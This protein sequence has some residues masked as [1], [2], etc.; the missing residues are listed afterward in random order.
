MGLEK[1][2]EKR[3]FTSSPEPKEEKSKARGPLR[4]VIQ[5]HQATRLHYDLRLEMHG[6]LKSW[7]VPKGP[8]LNPKDKRLAVMTEDHPIKYLTFEGVIPKGNYGAGVMH[9]WDTGTYHAID[10]DD[11]KK[12][13]KALISGLEEGD[14]KFILEGNIV[15]GEF[16]LIKA[17]SDEKN[18]LLIKKKDTHA[19]STAFNSE[20]FLPPEIIFHDK[21]KKGEKAAK[22]APATK[23]NQ[24]AAPETEDA[25]LAYSP[26]PHNVKP[27]LAQLANEPF[28]DPEWI[29]ELKWDGYRAIA[30]VE[31]SKVNIYSRNG[32]P[33]N[34][35]FF[36]LVQHLKKLGQ[37][38]VL[39]GEIVVLSDKGHP[40]FQKL[41]NFDEKDSDNLCFYVFDLL[42]LNGYD[43]TQLPL[44]ERKKL[45]REITEGLTN[46]FYS[47]HIKGEGKTFFKEAQKNK[48]EGIIA[49]RANSTY[50]IGARSKL[51]LKIK[52]SMRQE[53]IIAGFTEGKGSRKHF[54]SLLL[55]LYNGQKLVYIGNCGGGFNEE[56]LKEMKNKLTP[57]ITKENPFKKK[58]AAKAPITWVEPRLVCEITFSEW[59]EEGSMRHPIFF[60]LREDKDPTNVVKEVPI[61]EKEPMK[62]EEKETK[63]AKA[64]AA[65]PPKKRAKKDDPGLVTINGHELKLTNLDKIY[66]PEEKYTKGDL[67]SYYRTI[68]SYILPYLADRPES[69]HRHPNGIGKQSFFQKD[70]KDMPPDWIQT[71]EIHSES[72]DKDINYLVCQDEATLVYMNNLGCIEINPWNSRIQNLENPDYIVIDLDPGE[73]TFDEVIQTALE[74]KKVLDKA[75]AE[76]YCKTSGSSGLH[77][78][79]PLGAKY[80]YEDSR[81]FAHV[82][83]QLVLAQLPDLTSL[84]RS[85]KARKKK[86]YLDYLQNRI[87][88]TLA[89]PYGVRP[90]PGAT[91]SAPLEWKEVKKGLHPSKFTIK[92]MLQRVKKKG[93]LF[94]G[95]LGKGIDMEKCLNKL[96][97]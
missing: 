9:V 95:V 3:N 35:K 89:A 57:L 44:L 22:K 29:F 11:R 40:V 49:K 38:A 88:Q 70:M 74:V 5:R 2:K 94:K 85:P 30:E 34:H 69:L 76:G 39:D 63:K 20:E 86:I 41:Q 78:Y 67:I 55:G 96:S 64:K 18:W 27:M 56:S 42:H 7:A 80:N 77:I 15:K 84:E 65:A 53:A 12:S 10:Q 31:K 26:M 36:P 43:T 4:F 97:E 92:N 23:A 59:T 68:A 66:W 21:D 32:L 45:L 62:A 33:F 48:L 28:D 75:G 17:G 60:G 25:G 93:D 1:Y 90:K 61:E 13:E 54:G 58:I 83:A 8:S 16:A 24:S 87:G 50:N 6:V 91:V 47:D 72:N 19:V 14:L 46:I 51:W 37:N 71:I 52:T 82:I 81:N 73:N 79:I